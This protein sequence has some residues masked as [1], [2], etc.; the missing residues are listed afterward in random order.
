MEVASA[1]TSQIPVVCT[2][3]G[4]HNGLY[5]RPADC[6]V[7]CHGPLEGLSESIPLAGILGFGTSDDWFTR[8]S[9]QILSLWLLSQVPKRSALQTRVGHEQYRSTMKDNK[10]PGKSNV[11]FVRT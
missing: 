9:D 3:V 2:P 11:I 1:G 6:I 4:S 10:M 7:M 5:D 8:F